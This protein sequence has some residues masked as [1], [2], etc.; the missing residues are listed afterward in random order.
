LSS[1]RIDEDDE[2]LK[3]S[4]LPPKQLIEELK[5]VVREKAAGEKILAAVSGGVDST[6]ATLIAIHAVEESVVPVFIDTGFMREDEPQQVKTSFDSVSP[7]K[8]KIVNA[9]DRFY[10]AVR[11]LND[12]EKKRVAFREAFYSTLKE[13]GQSEGASLLLQ[14]TIAPD[15]IETKGG[16]KTQHN[17]LRQIGIRTEEKFGFQL[18]EPLAYLYKDQVRRLADLLGLPESFTRRQP[19]PGPGL[20][21]RTPGE[22]NPVRVKILRKATKIVEEKLDP[23][24]GSQWFAALFSAARRLDEPL[25]GG[26]ENWAFAEKV[27]GVKGDSRAYGGLLGV[28]SSSK[29]SP[30]EF[31]GKA[32]SLYL[33]SE[34]TLRELLNAS[35]EYFRLCVRLAAKNDSPNGYSLVVRAVKT[36]DFMTADILRP[37][38]PLLKYLSE[39]LLG[40]HEDV[41]DVF[42]DVTP[43][44]PA[45]IEYE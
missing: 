30:K 45:T 40:V 8:L 35:T 37:P 39:E 12:A 16:I 5:R 6:V 2:L 29:A 28:G 21:I 20:L 31:D 22:T 44:P 36:S 32:Y 14:G 26:V 41:R 43:K 7:V 23:L 9:E 24:G 25:V 33:E 27:T 34:T 17:V 19:F 11:G 3:M 42:Y 4:L 10:S 18:I 1:S 13:L 15:W 38:F